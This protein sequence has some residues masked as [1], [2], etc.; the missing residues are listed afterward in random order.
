MRFPVAA[1]IAS[2]IVGAIGGTPASPTRRAVH[3]SWTRVSGVIS[4]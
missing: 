4:M 1:K 3:C 2:Q